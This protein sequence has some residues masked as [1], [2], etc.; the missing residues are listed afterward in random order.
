MGGFELI[1]AGIR[2][3]SKKQSSMWPSLKLLVEKVRRVYDDYA[4]G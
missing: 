2:I 4:A 3:F 1:F